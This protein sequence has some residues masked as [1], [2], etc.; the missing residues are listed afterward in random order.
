MM[1]ISRVG[2]DVGDAE[3][4]DAV[5]CADKGDAVG[6]S[7]VG[8]GVGLDEDGALVGLVEGDS[9][10]P[11]HDR[12]STQKLRA[13]SMVVESAELTLQ[14]S[15]NVRQRRSPNQE[16]ETDAR[17]VSRTVPVQRLML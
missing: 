2:A 15:R 4:G 16:S 6:L 1:I 10:P 8:E 3:V 5:G 12:S 13:L 14:P 17:S 11:A 9:V 7:D